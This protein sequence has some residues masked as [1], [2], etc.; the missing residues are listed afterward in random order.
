MTPRYARIVAAITLAALATPLSAQTTKTPVKPGTPAA[1]ETR[2]MALARGIYRL[3]SLGDSALLT[4]RIFGDN[5]KVIANET[6]VWRSEDATIAEA[7]PSGAVTALGNGTTKV[8]AVAGSDSVFAVVIVEQRAAKLGFTPSSLIM[9]ALGAVAPVRAEQ[10]DARGNPL[11]G[12]YAINVGCKMRDNGVVAALQPGARIVS[13][14]QGATALVC[15]RGALRDSLPI[16]VRQEVFAAKIAPA[17]NV[18]LAVAGDTLRLRATAFDRLGKPMVDIR[19]LWTAVDTAIVEVDQI[20]GIV[21]GKAQGDGRVSA[22]IENVTD[23]VTVHVLAPLPEGKT[24]MRLVAARP[25]PPPAPVASAPSAP[26]ATVGAPVGG[27]TSMMTSASAPASSPANVVTRGGRTSAPLVS[28]QPSRGAALGLNLATVS[29]PS[30]DSAAIN[31]ILTGGVRASS[32]KTGRTYIVTPMAVQTEYRYIDPT[33]PN[34]VPVVTTGTLI[35]AEA[36]VAIT[37]SFFLRAHTASGELNAS[38][39]LATNTYNSKYSEAG[40]ALG[41]RALPWLGFA[42]G[43]DGRSNNRVLSGVEQWTLLSIGA[44][45]DLSMFS[46]HVTASI[47]L[48]FMPSVT[49]ASTG[50]SVAPTASMSGNAGVSYRAGWFTAG[51]EYRVES[52]EFAKKALDNSQR[53]DRVST[54][55]L[56]LGLH[57]GR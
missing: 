43:Y 20:N 45:S 54:L 35:G 10:R 51:V 46:D 19:A 47:G 55:R 11:K 27:G 39:G 23:T 8:W 48:A 24:L 26:V 13:R 53:E 31:A 32:A 36:E 16:V 57:F 22:K 49:V 37:N 4:A 50:A 40:V 12:D 34:D 41:Y 38:A 21:L 18:N 14:Q 28:R 6:I 9:N 42:I 3:T 5:F 33:I 17:E 2:I 30:A 25:T 44:Q 1:K 7:A 29:N 15:T 56:K 52:F